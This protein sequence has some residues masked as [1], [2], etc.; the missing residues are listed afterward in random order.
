MYKVMCEP[1]TIFIVPYRNR[2]EQAFFF[3][4]Y[5]SFILEDVKKYEIYFSH[6]CDTR[7]FNRGATRNIG[8]LAMKEK[9]PNHYKN[10]TFVFNDV[11]TIP[12]NKILPFEISC[13]GIVKH[14]YGYEYALGGIVSIK[15]IDFEKINGYPCFW[16]WGLEDAVLQRRCIKY[17][18]II[19]RNAFYKIGSPEILQLFD[20]MSRIVSKQDR[21][22]ITNDTGHD[23]LTSIRDL[24]YTI[25][26]VSE[27]VQD[28][29]YSFIDKRI[30]FINISS[31][32]TF[33][34][35]EDAT[36]YSYDIRQPTSLIMTGNLTKIP[37]PVLTTKDWSNIPYYPTTEEQSQ[38]I[39]K[40]L[41]LERKSTPPNLINVYNTHKGNIFTRG[42]VASSQTNL[43][44][45]RQLPDNPQVLKWKSH[46]RHVKR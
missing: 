43:T 4:K 38:T 26:T 30:F 39:L 35:F 11:D 10:I 17:G 37:N 41:Q 5:M 9:Y 16:G 36:Y 21:T 32:N 12:F 6:Q 44:Q 8:F 18:I 25:D 19:D 29:V 46:L 22:S 27:N 13:P 34:R 28:N 42:H 2:S 31:F 20:G 33:N 15:G 45:R 3:K 23:G 40:K 1:S 14:F 24:A 7:S